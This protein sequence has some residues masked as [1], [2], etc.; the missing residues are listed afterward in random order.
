MSSSELIPVQ[1][2]H[3]H[4][5][6]ELHRMTPPANGDGNGDGGGDIRLV[7]I[8][9]IDGDGDGARDG[10]GDGGEDKGHTG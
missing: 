5:N 4:S 3:H 10:G 6:H 8:K 1:R 7:K 9:H 2:Y